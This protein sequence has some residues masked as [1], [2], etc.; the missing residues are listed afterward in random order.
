MASEATQ[1]V[2]MLPNEST[3]QSACGM[4]GTSSNRLEAGGP[5]PP[6]SEQL[7]GE[8]IEGPKLGVN[9]VLLPARGQ[10]HVRDGGGD[11]EQLHGELGAH[12]SL[13]ERED[14]PIYRSED[15]DIVPQP[16]PGKGGA[17]GPLGA[18]LVPLAACDVAEDDAG[19]PLVR[20]RNVHQVDPRLIVVLDPNQ[21]DRMPR[22]QRRQ[23]CLEPPLAVLVLTVR[24]VRDGALQHQVCRAPV[25]KPLQAACPPRARTRC[26]AGPPQVAEH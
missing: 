12:H 26:G 14:V 20:V 9:D 7:G 13:Q 4:S 3:Q 16:Q 2:L 11:I 6:R 1:L 19:A 25:C 23:P 15:I 21:L 10:P 24:Y 8:E 22:K 18:P 17:V 5:S